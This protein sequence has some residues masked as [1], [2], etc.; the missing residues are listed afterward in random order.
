[1][2]L[3]ERLALATV[4]ARITHA[5]PTLPLLGERYEVLALVGHGG[6]GEVY[7]ARDRE[8][9]REVAIKVVRSSAASSV[10]RGR[11]L[12]EARALARLAHPNVVAVF[13]VLVEH[14]DVMMVMELVRGLSL[15]RWLGE[16]PRPWRVVLAILLAAGRGLAAAHQV[17]LVHGDVK[18]DNV[19]LGEDGRVRL[20][21]FGLAHEGDPA[22]TGDADSDA[23]AASGEHPTQ[24]HCVRGTIG[25][26]A[27]E[28][29]VGRPADARSDQLAFCLTLFEALYGRH[30]LRERPSAETPWP[31]CWS[32]VERPAK[33]DV[34]ARIHAAIMRGLAAD[35]AR[36]HPSMQALL[37]RLGA[38]SRRRP[39]GWLA[40]PAALTLLA[41]SSAGAVGS[42]PDLDHELAPGDT[43]A[44][45]D[46]DAFDRADRLSQAGDL[47]GARTLL[48]GERERLRETG[49]PGAIDAAQRIGVLEDTL[50]DYAAAERTLD[51][52]YF[53]A[54]AIGDDARAIDA[55]LAIAAMLAHELAR[56]DEAAQWL[57]HA[58]ALVTPGTDA[59]RWLR[60]EVAEA[61][62]LLARGHSLDAIAGYRRALDPSGG[63][64]AQRAW[65]HH[66][67]AVAYHRAGQDE[68][69]V[70]EHRRA[71]A[72]LEASH[73]ADHPAMATVLGNLG[74]ALAALGRSDEALAAGRRALE[75]REHALGGQHPDTAA[76]LL[77]VGA[78]LAADG[79]TERA[80]ACYLRALAIQRASLGAEHPDLAATMNNL[81]IVASDAHQA[82]AWYR[83]ALAIQERVL[84]PDHPALASVLGNLAVAEA[85]LGDREAAKEQFERALAIRER[86]FGPE[87]PQTAYPVHNLGV[88]ALEQGRIEEAIAL[89]ERA[90]RIRE[91]APAPLLLASTQLALARALASRGRDA[92]RVAAL[93]T[94]ARSAFDAADEADQADQAAALL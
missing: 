32:V 47:V 19:M 59:A 10:A 53:E 71:L 25:Y 30:A 18:P 14:G 55:A 63:D 93:A 80:R 90:L 81:G 94:A 54:I 60:V 38:S 77:S 23:C 15:R 89:L 73:G 69:A 57:R 72:L 87:H 22:I 11:L 46:V 4:E 36:R 50:G 6:M 85:E 16:R 65:T 9:A 31:R 35:P 1:M 76:S 67:L 70:I 48:V 58:R 21:D 37:E 13:D 75:I 41:A 26:L 8:L 62:L 43:P 64:D 28:L 83:D 84:P 88:I 12:G 20:I 2:S 7:R 52:A 51:A 34:P 17:G 42:P 44:R 86:A 79:E 3:A 49:D 78:L 61:G 24:I 68:R 45:N 29:G 5:P 33:S 74:N 40:I 92:Q 27:P 66:D 91:H 56:A 82:R 39:A